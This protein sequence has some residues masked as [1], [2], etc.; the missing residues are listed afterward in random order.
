MRMKTTNMVRA[1][2]RWIQRF[3]DV[4]LPMGVGTGYRTR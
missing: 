2:A 3:L 1:T 4:R